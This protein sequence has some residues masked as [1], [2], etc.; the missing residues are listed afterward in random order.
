[1]VAG[2]LLSFVGGVLPAFWN[3]SFGQIIVARLIY[4]LGFSMFASRN[5]VVAQSFGQ[6]DAALWMGRGTFLGNVISILGQLASGRLGDI[7]W[8]YSFLL[9][10]V[11]LG[12]MIVNLLL[13]REPEKAAE[14]S[15]SES[16]GQ[17]EKLFTPIVVIFALLSVCSA[18]CVYPY[19]SSISNFVAARGLGSA[20]QS[21]WAS[22]AFS[23]G[24]AAT[25]LL[26]GRFYRAL[27]RWTA[28]V[29]YVIVI[30]GYLCVLSANHIA[31]VVL[32]GV[33][34][35]A[36]NNLTVLFIPKR[37]LE[38]VGPSRQALAVAL[39]AGA[40]SFGSF[41]SSYFMVAARRVGSF[42]P[43]LHNEVEA[44]FFAGICLFLLMFAALA[45]L[46]MRESKKSA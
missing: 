19:I 22:A 8:R 1:M 38:S 40:I 6:K 16:A 3:Q 35:G 46:N 28:N 14:Q 34:C 11:C 42:L 2:S 20:S 36:G 10:F 44:A 27:G 31:M 12:A 25:A 30:L 29:G 26:F 9:Y 43:F 5:A 23:L 15:K 4:G 32:G 45:V 18:L 39:M 33:L 13:F 41:F 17:K 7:N 24:G 37:V 21:S